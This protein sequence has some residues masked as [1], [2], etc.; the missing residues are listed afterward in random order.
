[1]RTTKKANIL[2]TEGCERK[3]KEVGGWNVSV[4]IQSRSS[5]CFRVMYIFVT[6]CTNSLWYYF[7]FSFDFRGFDKI[8]TSS[9]L[10][11]FFRKDRRTTGSTRDEDHFRGLG[12]GENDKT[13]F[14]FFLLHEHRLPIE[15]SIRSANDRSL[16][17]PKERRSG[18]SNAKKKKEQQTP[19]ERRS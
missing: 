19:K 7:L 16:P 12:G 10:S 14:F 6:T 8:K 1:M 3:K 11:A 4:C 13:H 9:L 5:A 17:I 15:R 2:S 18:S